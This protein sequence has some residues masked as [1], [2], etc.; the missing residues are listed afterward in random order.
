MA[1]SDPELEALAKILEEVNGRFGGLNSA[2]KLAAENQTRATK[3]AKQDAEVYKRLLRE[4]KREEEDIIEAQKKG[5]LSYRE[6][7]IEIQKLNEKIRAVVPEDYKGTFENVVKQEGT[8][9]NLRMRNVN[10]IKAANFAT[11]L[12]SKG[13]T[14]SFKLMGMLGPTV[15]PLSAALDTATSTVGLVGSA[16]K[17]L[18]DHATETGLAVAALGP[19]ASLAVY[20][21][22]RFAGA[23]GQGLQFFANN[24]MPVFNTYVKSLSSGFKDA[25]SAGGLFAGGLTELQNTAFAAGVNTETFGKIIKEQSANLQLFGGDVVTGARRVAQ[26]TQQLAK[27]LG[28]NYQ[29]LFVQMGYSVEE[30]PG[31]I[32]QVGADVSRTLGSVSNSDVAKAVQDYARNLRVLS[33]LTGQ[34]A[35][36]LQE[37]AETE[38]R[39]LRYKQYLSDIEQRYG[40]SYRKQLELQAASLDPASL[41]QFKEQV[42]T[43]GDLFSQTA[44]VISGL[45]PATNALATRFRQVADSGKLQ[46]TTS[47]DLQF[48]YSKQIASQLQN[49]REAALAGLA[50]G[51]N[52]ES[53]KL[54]GESFDTFV[55]L[56]NQTIKEYES[57]RAESIAALE[58]NDKKTQTL[59]EAEI[60]G[61]EAKKRA[62]E[63]ATIALNHYLE[64]INKVN[65]LNIALIS[66][67]GR[68]IKFID[69]HIPG[70]GLP[71]AE[72]EA[73]NDRFMARIRD[74]HERQLQQ[75]ANINAT[76]AAGL[77]GTPTTNLNT[78]Q[79]GPRRI[80]LPNIGELPTDIQLVPK[81]F[82]LG[83]ISSGPRSGYLAKLHGTEAVL[84]ENLTQMLIDSAKSAQTLKEQ[85]PSVVNS[86]NMSEE[87]LSDINSKFDSMIDIL[88]SIS[89]HTENTAMRV[90]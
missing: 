38:F 15:D 84:P 46:I 61:L 82:D 19:E 45:A 12:F 66:S 36:T 80:D 54:M 6:A 35:K 9:T 40:A 48:Q 24:V 63:A 22:S 70:G 33:D 69:D 65:D 4:R 55:S 81:P 71:Q 25:A 87:L 53:L 20:G 89:G 73:E 16:L 88:T 49:N 18:G 13:L 39:D 52:T 31:I 59:A 78:N 77:V 90:A 2:I 62:E 44:G 1:L 50:T 83:G 7:A 27:N 21:L 85:L 58:T 86:R 79:N 5:N 56:A 23:A 64:G 51:E 28:P 76:T 26:V 11:D 34:N 10:A 74:S 42:A 41:I 37:K 30:I 60:K 29:N 8:L 14:H 3:D 17:F 32:A 75:T 47:R 67:T 68:L 72:V 43:G 57:K